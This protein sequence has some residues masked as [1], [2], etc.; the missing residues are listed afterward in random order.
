MRDRREVRALD[1]RALNRLRPSAPRSRFSYSSPL[2]LPALPDRRN[3]V[4]WA[5]AAYRARAALDWPAGVHSPPST[6]RR[7]IRSPGSSRE[8]L[9]VRRITEARV[10]DAEVRWSFLR[11]AGSA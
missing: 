11:I 3:T 2:H 6:D 7:S 4:A 5:Y 1:I 9:D 10:T 8:T